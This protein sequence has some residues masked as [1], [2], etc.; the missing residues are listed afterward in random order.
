MSLFS[1]LKRAAAKNDD[2]S[3]LPSE[4]SFRV[5]ERSEAAAA[6]NF[7]GVLLPKALHLA[8]QPAKSHVDIEDNIFCRPKI[9]PGSSTLHTL[10]HSR[11]LS[12]FRFRAGMIT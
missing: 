4:P 7:D 2:K 5:L 1:R 12:T 11:L 10:F 8:S 3:P 6:T 9:K